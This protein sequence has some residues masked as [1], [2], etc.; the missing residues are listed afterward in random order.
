MFPSFAWRPLAASVV[1]TF[2]FVYS[3]FSDIAPNGRRPTG[4]ETDEWSSQKVIST[5]QNTLQPISKK[6]WQINFDHPNF[7][8]LQ[9]SIW[10]WSTKNP[11]YDHKVLD[12]DSGRQFV[13]K[14]Y[15][16][17]PYIMNTYLEL[18]SLILRADY[19]RYLVLAAQGG[20]YSDLD[21]NA[22]R[23]I[24]TWLAEDSS[25]K[26][27]AMVGIEWDQLGGPTTPEGLYMPLQFCQWSLAFSAHHTLMVW[28]VKAVT[29]GLHDLARVHG[30]RLSELHPKSNEDVLFTT[31]PVKWSQ[32]IFAYLSFTSGTEVTHQNFTG[33]AKPR[34]I[35]DVM[36]L[37]VDSFATGVGHSGSSATTTDA[38][39]L[40]HTFQGSWK[41]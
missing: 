13:Q 2:I 14:H 4:F 26:T 6:I 22:V 31:G 15:S 34:L 23:P 7:E 11:S 5:H 12:G 10:T 40:R 25:K 1:I 17:D 28:M 24:D 33:L 35:G 21:T 16:H 39:L 20:I 18:K 36:I 30:V 32:E 29:R 19:L 9:K 27:R 3:W 41:Y 37:P 8:T 38:T